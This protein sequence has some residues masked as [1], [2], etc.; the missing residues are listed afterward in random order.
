MGIESIVPAHK[1]QQDRDRQQAPE[2]MSTWLRSRMPPRK[3]QVCIAD[4]MN[5]AV[6]ISLE[7]AT[8]SDCPSAQLNPEVSCAHPKI[9]STCSED[10]P[11]TQWIG[12]TRHR[13]WYFL[14]FQDRKSIASLAARPESRDHPMPEP[15]EP[16]P[17]GREQ[18][19]AGAAIRR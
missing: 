3:L 1:Q 10:V 9:P 17:P 4:H 16:A 2:L 18:S 6:V 13:A 7:L 19:L 11:R 5:F 14:E 15:P 12:Q 8:P